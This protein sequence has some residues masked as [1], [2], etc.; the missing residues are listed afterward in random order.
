MRRALA[1]TIFLAACCAAAAAAD[2]TSDLAAIASFF[3]RTEGSAEEAG[4]LAWIDARVAETGARAVAFDFAQSAE[5]YSRSSCRSIRIE[6]RLPDTL[7][8]V[9]PLNHDIDA[10]P[11]S[12]G[13]VNIALALELVRRA[14]AAVPPVSIEVLF[15]G[16][17]Y[18]G[19]DGYPM[20]SALY[21]RDRSPT[22]PA[23]VVYLAMR[24]GAVPVEVCASGRATGSPAWLVDRAT[25]ALGGTDVAYR[26]STGEL[27]VNRLGLGDRKTIVDPWLLAG[28]PAIALE[29]AAPGEGAPG[30][31]ALEGFLVR[32]LE[33]SVDGLGEEWDNHHLPITIGERT[34]VL[35]EPV[36]VVLVAGTL[37]LLLLSS[38]VFARGL[39]KYLRALG[40]TGWVL[41][42]LLAVATAALL[43]A[44]LGLEGLLALRGFPTLWTWR[45]SAFLVAKLAA[46]TLLAGAALLPLTRLG[47]GRFASF[48][49]AAALLLLLVDVLIVT[50]IDV[51][52]AGPFLWAFGWVFLASRARRRVLKLLL[53]LPSALP[54]AIGFAAALSA[55]S[56]PLARFLLFSR[57]WGNLLI[58]VL[59]LPFLMF[60]LRVAFALPLRRRKPGRRVLGV[61]AVAL[62][63]AAA[64]VLGA[65]AALWSPFSPASPRPVVVEQLIGLDGA[66]RIRLSSPVPLGPVTLTDGGGVRT[67][68]LAAREAD[69]DLSASPVDV[70]VTSRSTTSLGRVNVALEIAAPAPVRAMRAVLRGEAGFV[71]Y[72]CTFPFVREGDGSYRLLAGA[73]PP[74]PLTLGLTLPEG[75]TYR[76]DLELELDSTL[77][78]ARV[79]VPSGRLEE[80]VRLLARVDI[81]T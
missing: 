4:L 74:S 61:L 6:G 78:G 8:V 2:F 20:G 72:D 50:A 43:A 41:A 7:I 26:L 10:V 32:F 12:C 16:A 13:D 73:F 53:F 63:A 45:P 27:A 5:G 15:L 46:A 42:P 37:A 54:I 48:F 24:A 3:P 81:R 22:V 59:A 44:T 68:D 77:L 34:I 55:P 40:R 52:L 60:L 65:W 70:V 18:G 21:L 75:R 31:A 28:V 49:S 57:G 58:A 11:G 38:L 79:A 69:I 67:L 35:G 23:A 30:T 51:S 29:D 17:E 14:R 66:N 80:N 19:G 1:V 36:W 76:L 71:L 56:L 33:L 47:I 39:K 62:P 9:A 64:A 25:S